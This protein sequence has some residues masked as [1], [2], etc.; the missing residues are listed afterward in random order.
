MN[1]TEYVIKPISFQTSFLLFFLFGVI[2]AFNNYYLIP[3]I[4]KLIN[5]NPF[6]ISQVVLSFLLF[7]PIFITT[8]ALLSQDKININLLNIKMRLSLKKLVI[9]DI[10]WIFGSLFVAIIITGLI[11]FILYL[12]PS[13]NLDSIERISPITLKPLEGYE[14]FF[15]LFMPISWFFNYVG[16]EFLWRGYLYPRQEIVFGNRTWI[17]NGLLHGIFHFYMGLPVILFLPL[18][19]SISFVYNKT[20]N[21]SAVIIM[22]ALLGVP[23]DFL[24]AIGVLK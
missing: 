6:I 14:L 16:E 4:V 22:H 1:D 21:T 9:K 5:V 10:F 18:I 7:I 8:F 24:L 12:I 2:F 23:M 11:L 13:F 3:F 17:I 15:L 19:L 20:R